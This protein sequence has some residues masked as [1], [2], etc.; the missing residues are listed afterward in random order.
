MYE[1]PVIGVI[2]FTP[3]LDRTDVPFN[4]ISDRAARPGISKTNSEIGYV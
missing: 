2:D 4:D 3:L 1:Q